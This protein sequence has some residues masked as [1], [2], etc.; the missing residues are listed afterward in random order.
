MSTVINSFASV[1]LKKR[2]DLLLLNLM[3]DGKTYES[4][5]D[6]GSSIS[7]MSEK[8]IVEEDF[9]PRIQRIFDCYLLIVTQYLYMNQLI[10]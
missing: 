5:L 9:K 1:E 8:F 3:I 4:F 6:T 10:Q 7:V 2:K